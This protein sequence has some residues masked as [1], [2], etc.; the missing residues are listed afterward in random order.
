MAT[1]KARGIKQKP[2]RTPIAVQVAALLCEGET[3]TGIAQRMKM[4]RE[5]AA[6]VVASDEVR[7]EVERINREMRK[8]AQQKGVALVGK[9]AKVWAEAM[10]AETGCPRCGSREE[11]HAVRL[12]AA[13]AVADR[14]GLPKT[15]IQEIA[16]AAPLADQSDEELERSIVEE[17]ASIFDRRGRHA[18]AAAI[19]RGELPLAEA[20]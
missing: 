17:A 10:T 3:T 14:F 5:K 11:D 7:E 18:L 16:A 9:V 13:E 1:K 15:S 8:A 6:L 12:R 20:V 4:G 2:S 19:R